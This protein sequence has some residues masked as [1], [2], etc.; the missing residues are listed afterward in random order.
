MKINIDSHAIT[1]PCPTCGKELKEKLGRLKR[2]K[3][4]ACPVCGR[5]AVNTDKLRGIE[6]SINKE[7]AKLS[8]KFTFK[9]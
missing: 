8:G 4:I 9:L 1:I 3:Y 5:I 7:L 2:D 6:D